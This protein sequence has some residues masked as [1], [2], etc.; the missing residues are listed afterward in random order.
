GHASSGSGRSVKGALRTDMPRNRGSILAAAALL[1]GLAMGLLS[2]GGARGFGP[3]EIAAASAAAADTGG[4]PLRITY[5]AEGTLF[6]PESVAPT[7]LWE[8]GTAAAGP[9]DVVV[10][11]DGG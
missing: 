9:W 3:P 11:D 8:D 2:I 1:L 6:P 10:R 4:A 7:F 5:P